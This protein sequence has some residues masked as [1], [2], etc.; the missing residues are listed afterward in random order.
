MANI[1]QLI[2]PPDTRANQP[3]AGI[4]GRIYFV[5]DEGVLER[6]NGTAWEDI[7]SVGSGMTNPMTTAGD[8]IYGGAS[9]VPARL[10]KGTAAQVFAMNAGATA[11]EWVTAAA[12]AAAK[13]I[14]IV[15]YKTGAVATGTT[16]IPYDDTIPQNTE[17]TEFMTLAIT[18][19]SATN[20][21][22]IDIVLNH[23]VSVASVPAFALFQ[24]TTANALAAWA[25]LNNDGT[26]TMQFVGHFDMVAGTTSPTTF[27]VRAGLDRAGTLAINGNSSGARKYGGVW[28]SAIQIMEVV[29]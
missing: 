4:P 20:K 11:P 27:K 17:G 13:L 12:P 9:G 10:A 3:A 22:V 18:P 14:Q 25:V 15:E 24:D 2:L 21:L 23:A 16:A 1:E 26:G 29:P 6:D 28:Y 8:V 19:T 5:T 7:S